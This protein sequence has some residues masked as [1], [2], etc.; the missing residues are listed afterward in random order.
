M[1]WELATLFVLL[2]VLQILFYGKTQ[3]VVIMEI[4]SILECLAIITGHFAAITGSALVTVAM[5]P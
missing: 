1:V 5:S 3:V 2:I 4:N